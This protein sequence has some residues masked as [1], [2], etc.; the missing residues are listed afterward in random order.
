MSLPTSKSIYL[1]T[2]ETSAAGP[3]QEEL[4]EQLQKCDI[5]ASRVSS[6]VS[7][8]APS[9][10]PSLMSIMYPGLKLGVSPAQAGTP[11]ALLRSLGPPHNLFQPIR[12]NSTTG[13]NLS[14]SAVAGALTTISAVTAIPTATPL[15]LN[16]PEDSTVGERSS[17][18]GRNLQ[19]PSK[20]TVRDLENDSNSASDKRTVDSATN[21]RP[22]SIGGL[23][24]HS[25]EQE[26]A[27]KLS[28]GEFGLAHQRSRSNEIDYISRT[29]KSGAANASFQSPPG[30]HG[31]LRAFR[32]VS[33][34]STNTNSAFFSDTF[35]YM[36]P[37]GEER[38]SGGNN[39]TASQSSRTFTPDLD[40][41]LGKSSGFIVRVSSEGRPSSSHDY[42]DS[43][44]RVEVTD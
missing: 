35:S 16:I 25:S 17:H 1:E 19:P 30:S 38:W 8:R 12:R 42:P 36:M 21:N 31:N 34:G 40:G 2:S 27:V 37:E 32:P 15:A 23:R 13:S 43:E 22:T 24:N 7:S 41:A 5:S 3:T 29:L 9:P 26:D 20:E 44:T 4:L 10:S 14:L 6:A 11:T 33:S 18:V 39:L 28:S